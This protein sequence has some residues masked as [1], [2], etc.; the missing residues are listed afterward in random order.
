MKTLKIAMLADN[1]FVMDKRIY[2]EAKALSGAGYD[3]VLF[4]ERRNDLPDN[5]VTD[6]I[7]VKRIFDKRLFDIKQSSYL[8]TKA[9]EVAAFAPD[10]VHCH[11]W[12]MLHIGVLVK[13]ILPGVKIIYD[14]HELFS[15]WPIHYSSTRL[16]IRLKTWLVR[17][18]EIWRERRDAKEIDWLITVS[19]SIAGYLRN[20]LKL[21]HNPILVRN[22]ADTEQV[23]ERSDYV[24]RHFNIPAST[25]VVVLFAYLIYRKKR[26][27]ETVIQ[28]LGD[29]KNI[30]LVI[31]CKTGGHKD[32]FV[33]LVKKQGYSNIYFHEAIPHH[34]IVN[35]LASCDVGVIPTWNKK[36]LSYW[37][38]LENKLFHYVM[39]ELPVLCSAT[40]EHKLIVEQYKIGVCA[41]GDKEDD[42]YKALEKI[43]A[44]YSFYKQNVIRAKSELCWEKEQ[45][46]LLFL[47][48]NL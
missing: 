1:E 34:D 28:Q 37:L 9:K 19:Q 18:Y 15:S 41:D 29:R 27:I 14:S 44:D 21:Y 6:G 8:K 23:T 46:K 38:G 40:P 25:K 35:T 33:N 22:F 12:I 36:H 16:D 17:K 31:F 42:Y 10:V 4:A 7:V 13:K 24:R 32:Y 3:L 48:N 30:V 2:R 43:L 45:E 39:S 47:Y 5:E 20:Y 26:N 11:D